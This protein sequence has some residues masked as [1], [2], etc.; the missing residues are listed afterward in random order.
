MKKKS[1]DLLDPEKTVSLVQ[2][3]LNE[4]SM[5]LDTKLVNETPISHSLSG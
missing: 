5:P 1:E 4:T 3:L 2:S